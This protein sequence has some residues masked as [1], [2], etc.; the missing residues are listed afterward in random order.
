MHYGYASLAPASAL[1]A[2]YVFGRDPLDAQR[3]AAD[4]AQ[5]LRASTV[6]EGCKAAVVVLDQPLSWNSGCRL[7][8]CGA[9]LHAMCW[10]N[11]P[12]CMHVR[13]CVHLRATLTCCHPRTPRGPAIACRAPEPLCWF[14]R[15][16]A[17][18]WPP[19][20]PYV[21]AYPGALRCT[22]WHPR[23]SAPC[24]CEH[25]QS[26]LV[27]CHTCMAGL[28]STDCRAPEPPCWCTSS[29]GSG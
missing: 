12:A 5:H 26:I 13:T 8:R 29:V 1:P 20:C 15:S 25:W 21:T 4:V 18:G 7:R 22:G 19:S 24:V 23:Q 3:C 14:T 11:A 6:L 16:V 27:C 10:C 2:Y 17:R 28:P 9:A